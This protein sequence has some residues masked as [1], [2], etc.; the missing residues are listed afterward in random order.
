[1]EREIEATVWGVGF[2]CILGLMLWGFIGIMEKW[3]HHE[4]WGF[5]FGVCDGMLGSFRGTTY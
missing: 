3:S 1:M 4:I 5:A 2:H